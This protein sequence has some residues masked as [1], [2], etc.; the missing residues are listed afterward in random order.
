M[1]RLVPLLG[2]PDREPTSHHVRELCPY[3][4]QEAHERQKSVPVGIVEDNM[5]EE[6]KVGETPAQSKCI[7]G[8][9]EYSDSSAD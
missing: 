1:Y 2:Q 5:L 4:T 3:I 6:L 7:I 9:L 8:L